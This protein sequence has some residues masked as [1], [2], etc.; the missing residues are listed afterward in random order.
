[1]LGVSVLALTVLAVLPVL[2][3]NTNT[4]A[5]VNVSAP[6]FRPH[7][8]YLAKAQL[9]A[10]SGQTLTVTARSKTYT[11]NVTDKTTLRRRFGSKSN[12]GEFVVGHNLQI[13]GKLTSGTTIEARAIRNM[14]IQKLRATFNGSI[15]SIDAANSKFVLKPTSRKT[16]TVTV[17]ADTKITQS[18]QA[19]TFADLTVGAKVTA[20]GVWDK[21]NDTLTE[22]SKVVIR[23]A[24]AK[25]LDRA[26]SALGK[27][28][29]K[30]AQLQDRI[31]ELASKF[32]VQ[33]GQVTVSMSLSGFSPAEIRI[34]KGTTVVFQN[35]DSAPHWPASA[36][37]PTH[38]NYPEFDPKQGING[39]SSWSF[40]FNKPGVWLYHDHLNPSLHGKVTVIDLAAQANTTTSTPA[41]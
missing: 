26:V 18:G 3:Q 11:V 38:T 25:A 4:N 31:R 5:N 22:V 34:A 40:A 6:I 20:S 10:I 24:S 35:S 21:S 15:E 23:P 1:M 39:G 14:S 17:S 32:Q 2:A 19:K 29:N 27:A 33:T 9:T 36:P 13:V 37:H 12:L 41:Q 8:I 30:V 16:I 7:S 28:T